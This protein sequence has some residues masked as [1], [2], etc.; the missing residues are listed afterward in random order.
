MSDHTIP[1]ANHE[2]AGV[3]MVKARAIIRLLAHNAHDGDGK[4]VAAAAWAAEDLVTEAHDL[5]GH[6]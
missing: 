3:M 1:N 6:Y 4:S 2:K 5:Y